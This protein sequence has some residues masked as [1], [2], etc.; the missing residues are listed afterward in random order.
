VLKH[1]A[2]LHLRRRIQLLGA[3]QN[4]EGQK[5]VGGRHLFDAVTNSSPKGGKSDKAVSDKDVVVGVALVK[6]PV[7][8]INLALQLLH[9]PEHL[10]RLLIELRP[11]A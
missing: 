11:P 4:L 8:G 7:K 5:L 3:Q 1:L 2:P 9:Q 6:L 10:A